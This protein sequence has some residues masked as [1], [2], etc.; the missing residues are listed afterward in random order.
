MCKIKIC[1]FLI[2]INLHNFDKLHKF[3]YINILYINLCN[4]LDLYN[5]Y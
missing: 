4:L 3:M 5:W 2:I 1:I